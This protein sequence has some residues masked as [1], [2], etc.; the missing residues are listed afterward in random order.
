MH[1]TGAGDDGDM[2]LREVEIRRRMVEVLVGVDQV[3]YTGAT[4]EPQRFF[5]FIDAANVGVDQRGAT[6]AGFDDREVGRAFGADDGENGF[7]DLADSGFH[8]LRG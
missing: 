4:G 3:T 1:A 8:W 2:L 7:A 5:D 6:V